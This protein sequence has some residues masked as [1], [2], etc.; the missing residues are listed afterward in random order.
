MK[1]CV[2][3]ID[4]ESRIRFFLIGGMLMFENL[5]REDIVDIPFQYC[6]IRVFALKYWSPE[7][8]GFR[9]RKVCQ[10]FQLFSPFGYKG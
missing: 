6:V 3:V 10:I 5:C 1:A 7:F 2:S 4:Q 8:P 9:Q